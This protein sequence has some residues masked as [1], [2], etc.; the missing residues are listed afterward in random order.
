MAVSREGFGVG[1]LDLA[2]LRQQVGYVSQDVTLFY[3]SL[4]ENLVLAH[5]QANDEDV[6]RAAEFAHLGEFVNT[7]PKGFD[8][9]IGERGESISGEC[10]PIVVPSS[11]D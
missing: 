4:R 6:I 11:S 8:M 1:P 7:H 3:G 9:T 10:A 2:V 5:P